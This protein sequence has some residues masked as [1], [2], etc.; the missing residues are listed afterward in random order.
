MA[1]S[2]GECTSGFLR[3]KGILAM[4]ILDSFNFCFSWE[5]LLFTGNNK[6]R[7][8]SK[9]TAVFAIKAWEE[10]LPLLDPKAA[11]EFYKCGNILQE[12]GN[13]ELVSLDGQA[14]EKI[15]IGPNVHY[16][17]PSQQI[18]VVIGTIG[19]K[20][21]RRMREYSEAKE[22]ILAYYL[23]ALGVLAMNTVHRTS[24]EFLQERAQKLTWGV[25]PAMKPG[26]LNGWGVEGQRDILRL[27]HG[28]EIGVK[29]NDSCL[30]IPFFSGSYVVGM[31]ADFPDAQIGSLCHECARYETCDWRRESA[32]A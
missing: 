2:E 18:C 20:L 21:E 16:L 19:A 7:G 25:G 3:Q 6:K 27:A 23:N 29:I 5:D 32:G 22:E 30:L 10:G 11:V 24:R 12:S 31:G 14:K 4:V 15:H 1:Y 28:G 26:S 17:T 13:I 8:H 9:S